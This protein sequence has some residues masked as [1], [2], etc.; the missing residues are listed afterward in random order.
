M[1][2]PTC[3][4][5]PFNCPCANFDDNGGADGG[6]DDDGSGA[7][8]GADG[9]RKKITAGVS[10]IGDKQSSRGPLPHV[11]GVLLIALVADFMLLAVE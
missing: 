4:K 3:G 5:D 11:L 7:S 1:A 6:I 2:L 9:G 10:S 8:G